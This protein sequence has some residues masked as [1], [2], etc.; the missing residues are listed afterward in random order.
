[1][2]FP[3]LINGL[4][5][6]HSREDDINE[7]LKDMEEDEEP[8]DGLIAGIVIAVVTSVLVVVSLVSS[9]I[10]FTK[11]YLFSTNLIIVNSF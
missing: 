7:T 1:M 9:I 3:I 5:T 6:A 11:Q 2:I 4:S 8:D 10:N